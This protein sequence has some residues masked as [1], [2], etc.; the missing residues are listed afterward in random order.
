MQFS[1]ILKCNLRETGV[2]LTRPASDSDHYE[3]EM[4]YHSDG[5]LGEYTVLFSVDDMAYDMGCLKIIPLSHKEYV[6]GVGHENVR[7]S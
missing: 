6:D 2:T 4:E 3:G 1:N 7:F 5:A